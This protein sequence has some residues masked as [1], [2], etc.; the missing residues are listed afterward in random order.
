MADSRVTNLQL[1]SDFFEEAMAGIVLTHSALDGFASEQVPETFRYETDNGG[2]LSREEVL[3]RGIELRL[4]RVLAQASGSPNVRTSNPDLW[5]R[6]EELKGVRDRIAHGLGPQF[7]SSEDP[8]ENV[9]ARLAA[10]D[11]GALLESVE[12]V[13]D[14]Y[15]GPVGPL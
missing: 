11:F 14:H 2:H 9:F 13:I 15:L 1:Y 4:T 8:M 5:L 3:R 10:R 7:I 12:E 6:V